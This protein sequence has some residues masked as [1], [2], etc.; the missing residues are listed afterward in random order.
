MANIATTFVRINLLDPA[1]DLAE[2]DVLE[3]IIGSR[4]AYN[5]PL[6]SR[7]V[8]ATLDLHSVSGGAPK[9]SPTASGPAGPDV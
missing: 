9:V 2:R 3:E 5:V 7:R 1:D 4:G 6:W 8:D